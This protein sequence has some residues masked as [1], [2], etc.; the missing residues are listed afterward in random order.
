MPDPNVVLAQFASPAAARAAADDYRAAFDE[1][2]DYLRGHPDA[3]AHG[4]SPP[5]HA[6]ARR[7][8]FAWDADDSFSW[9]DV[10]PLDPDLCI[11]A[12]GRVFFAGHSAA[13]SIA[14]V[15]LQALLRARSATEVIAWRHD[16]TPLTLT[17]RFTTTDGMNWFNA[18]WESVLGPWS[19]GQLVDGTAPRP[20]SSDAIIV[21][22]G[23]GASAYCI[24]G[25]SWC[26]IA[27][28]IQVASRSDVEATLEDDQIRV[29]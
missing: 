6:F 21:F 26:V 19:D 22:T 7:A 28:L 14:E 23:P 9:D 1:H 12:V 11:G 24:T 17:I 25:T 16:T 5:L 20:E 15:G 29:R 10:D 13:A 27:P 18:N 2:L 4:V 3:P 8:G